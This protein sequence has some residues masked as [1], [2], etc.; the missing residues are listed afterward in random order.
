MYIS[1]SNKLGLET[2]GRSLLSS[3]SGTERA[4]AENSLVHYV[5]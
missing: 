4:L 1:F 2:G 3:G 5:G